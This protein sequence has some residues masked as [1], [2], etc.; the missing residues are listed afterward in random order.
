MNQ[1]DRGIHEQLPAFADRLQAAGLYIVP[2][3]SGQCCTGRIL[4][5]K[6]FMEKSLIMPDSVRAELFDHI[7]DLGGMIV[8]G[9]VLPER[10][11]FDRI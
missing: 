11:L 9:T 5:K 10:G 3:R 8:E 4:T 1:V 2:A 6:Q 7:A